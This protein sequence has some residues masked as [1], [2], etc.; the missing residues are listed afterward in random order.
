MEQTA[1]D[2][3]EYFSNK[4]TSL[5]NELIDKC[6]ENLSD[7]SEDYEN[8]IKIKN[9]GDKLNYEKIIIKLK[10][11]NKL[12]ETI[13]LLTK[14]NSDNDSYYELLKNKEKY[15]I[16]LPSFNINNIIF[17]ITDRKIHTEIF[18][19]VNDLHV[20]ALT[21]YKVIEQI[22]QCENDGKEFNPF[23]SIG[24]VTNNM[25]I[26]TLYNGV[27]NKTISAY[28]MIMSAI[29]NQETNNKMDEYMNNIKECD[30]HEAASKLNDVIE[31]DT[32][33]GNKQTSKLLSEMLVNIKDEV[34]NLKNT[35]NTQGKQGVENLLGIAQKVAGSMMNKIK[36][37]DVS[38]LQ[39]WDATSSLAKETV[40]S[41]ALNLV[42]NL[43][44][45]NI[46]AN[47]QK[48]QA[49]SVEQDNSELNDSKKEKKS[50]SKKNKK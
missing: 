32:F 23:E 35:N 18:S 19:K 12:I 41:D 37:S 33:Q 31:S 4:F 43:I 47:L 13:N 28:D 8:L 34:I 9:Y 21:Y 11:N 3:K 7:N 39:I 26:Q 10:D 6:I 14:N 27:E 22:N 1:S 15:W 38:V 45:S 48:P 42:D 40:Q 20:C 30:V 16:I 17:Q 50:K 5:F 24:N 29:I 36:D 44:R 49:S 46:M 2:Y 25:D